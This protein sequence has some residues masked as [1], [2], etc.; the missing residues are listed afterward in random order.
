[1]FLQKHKRLVG[2]FIACVAGFF[3]PVVADDMV[4]LVE[5]DYFAETGNTEKPDIPSEFSR[6]PG[7]YL[8]QPGDVLTVSVWKEDDLQGDVMVRPDGGISFPLIGDI[9]VANRSIKDIQDIITDKLQRYIPEPSVSVAT[10]S[11]AGNKIYILGKVNRP[12][13][14]IVTRKVDV[15]QALSMAGGLTPY[16]ASRDIKVLRRVDEQ[17]HVF[18]FNYRDMEHGEN[19]SQNIALRS[20]DV[21]IVP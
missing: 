4:A 15:L 5:D 20:G 8:V 10:K 7:H 11:I 9:A 19:L 17:Q 21:V 2:L 16:A 6:L 12:G 13:E 1:M 18:D 14:F 3:E